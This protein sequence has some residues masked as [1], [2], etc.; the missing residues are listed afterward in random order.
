[1]S[2]LGSRA[3][4]KSYP[5]AEPDARTMPN[6]QSAAKRMRQNAKHRARN[7]EQRAELRTSIKKTQHAIDAQAPDSVREQMPH[8]LHMIGKAAQKGLIH[9]NKAAR[10]VSRLARRLNALENKAKT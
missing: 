7:R 3:N 8:T 4:L 10:Q 5:F 9:K 1:M 2:V 6:I